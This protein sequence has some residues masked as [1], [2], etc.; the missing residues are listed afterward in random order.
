LIFW[1]KNVGHL[2]RFLPVLCAIIVTSKNE[3][4]RQ[5]V[6]AQAKADESL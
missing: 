6:K 3:G 5:K 2:V 4:Q 1:D